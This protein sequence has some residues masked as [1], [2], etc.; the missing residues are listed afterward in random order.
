MFLKRSIKLITIL[1]YLNSW[2]K[3]YHE[4]CCSCWKTGFLDATRV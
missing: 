4:N 1:C 2:R 3:W